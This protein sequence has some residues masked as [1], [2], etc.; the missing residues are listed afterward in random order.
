MSSRWQSDRDVD[1][2][3]PFHADGELTGV[4]AWTPADPKGGYGRRGWIRLS[5]RHRDGRRR[6]GALGSHAR[7]GDSS[8]RCR[9]VVDGPSTQWW[10]ATSYRRARALGQPDFTSCARGRER[11]DLTVWDVQRRVRVDRPRRRRRRV[12]LRDGARHEHS[13]GDAAAGAL[14]SPM[15]LATSSID[16]GGSVDTRALPTPLAPDVRNRAPLVI[17]R[18]GRAPVASRR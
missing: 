2:D 8:R 4:G 16:L 10:R 7:L 6:I 1:V 12:T 17:P 11:Q 18:V 14:R 3:L 15:A 9:V 5:H 13:S